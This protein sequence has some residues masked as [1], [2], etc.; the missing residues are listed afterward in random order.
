M[1]KQK[2]V[3]FR[4]KICTVEYVNDEFAEHVSM[5]SMSRFT[6]T[7]GENEGGLSLKN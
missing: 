4:E 7:S 2:A 5:K 3:S 6:S 1:N